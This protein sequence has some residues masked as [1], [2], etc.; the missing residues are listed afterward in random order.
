MTADAIIKPGPAPTYSLRPTDAELED[1]QAAIEKSENA[2]FTALVVEHFGVERGSKMWPSP[3]PTDSPFDTYI[4]RYCGWSFEQRTCGHFTRDQ[5]R[6][7]IKNT[8][9]RMQAHLRGCKAYK[10]RARG[11]D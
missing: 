4:C 10:K 3:D 6:T 9:R 1:A 11:H 2:I 5:M 7:P 8:V